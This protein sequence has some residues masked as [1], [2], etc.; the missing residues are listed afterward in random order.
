MSPGSGLDHPFN[1]V[2]NSIKVVVD[3]YDGTVDFY[4]IDEVD[5][6]AKVWQSAF[7]GLFKTKAQ[8]P[9]GLDSHFRYPEELFRVQTAA[10]SKYRLSPETFFGRTGA[11]SV[12]QAPIA[13]PRAGVVVAAAT[14]NADAEA[15]EAQADL[16]TES[17]TERFVPYYSMLRSPGESEASFKLLRPFV[18]FSTDD[19]KRNLQAFMTASSDPQDY[20][21]LV[22][23][24]VTSAEDGPFT[25]S[26]TMNS[27][28]TIS[29]QLSLLNIEG[30]DVVFG[31]L[32]MVPLAG[33]LLWVRPV[34]VQPTVLDPRVSQPTIELV[35]VSQSNNAAYGSSLSGALAK[36]FPGFDEEIGD[37]V[38]DA[39]VDSGD[40]GDARR[41]PTPTRRQPIYSTKLRR[42]SPRP[43]RRSPT[44]T[45]PPTKRESNK[46]EPW[47]NRRSTASTRARGRRDYPLPRRVHVA[48]RPTRRDLRGTRS[49][50]GPARWPASPGHHATSRRPRR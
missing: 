44:A 25:V 30:T 28:S 47:C 29:Q 48:A 15:S 26:N 13:R 19:A 3:G 39:P 16:A 18:P 40:D 46:L 1:Y 50:S 12:A 22:A 14:T 32:Q 42:C 33:G 38:G 34:Y 31:D 27:E 21:S 2:R 5:P 8:M 41:R 7:P 17:G 11:W 36:L 49:R 24:E 23:Y 9:V 4:I 6:V 37:V 45:W 35:L 20:G 10:Y 43:T